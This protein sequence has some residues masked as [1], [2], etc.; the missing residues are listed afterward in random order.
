MSKPQSA[1]MLCALLIAGLSSGCG[2]GK[3]SSQGSSATTAGD[4]STT[5]STPSTGKR[6]SMPK[7]SKAVPALLAHAV[8]VPL[9]SSAIQGTQL[10]AEFTCD[11]RDVPPPLQWGKVPSQAKELVLFALQ[12][13]SREGALLVR[14]AVAGIK[15]SVHQIASNKLPAGAF[16]ETDSDEKA[17]YAICPAHGTTGYFKF[18]LY[19][20]P[21]KFTAGKFPG[22]KLLRNLTEVTAEFASPIRGEF[23][24]SYTRK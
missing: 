8:K 7:A 20:L 17:H 21:G 4:P 11:G 3:S 12:A 14:W 1:A 2:S 22:P 18:A 6:Y 13:P 23:S 9:S 24:V 16:L 10:P 5:S 15:P 19:A